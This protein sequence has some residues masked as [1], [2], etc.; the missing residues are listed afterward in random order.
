MKLS[1]LFR[2]LCPYCH[3]RHGR[4]GQ[5]ALHADVTCAVTRYRPDVYTSY[6]RLEAEPLKKSHFPRRAAR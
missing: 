6:A 5:A 4:G 3:R 2:R 1:M